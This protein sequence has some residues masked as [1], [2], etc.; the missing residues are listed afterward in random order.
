M[1]NKE[2]T[3]IS[4]GVTRKEAEK[5]DCEVTTRIYVPEFLKKTRLDWYESNEMCSEG[6]RTV[7]GWVG[8]AVADRDSFDPTCQTSSR[9]ISSHTQLSPTK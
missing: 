9:R 8:Y 5:D 7:D 2:F 3:K 1:G 4:L 6:D